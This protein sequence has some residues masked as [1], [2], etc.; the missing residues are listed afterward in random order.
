MKN[1]TV[2]NIILIW[3]AWALIVIGF[4]AL[5]TARLQPTW[6][7]R[8]LDW[9]TAETGPAYQ[10]NR[11]YLLEPF[12][13]NQVAW[14]SEYYL[15]TAIGGY[16]DPLVPAMSQYGFIIPNFATHIPTV[17]AGPE[18]RMSL[19][20]AFLPLYPLLI[21]FVAYPLSLLG[22][23]AIA[24]A[25]LAAVLVSLLGTLAG[26]LASSRPAFSWPK[27]IP[28]G[29]LSAWLLAVWRCSNAGIL[30]RPLCLA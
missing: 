1:S 9:T 23:N 2:R 17:V 13:N 25:T 28:K 6:P 5:A 8:A 18:G 27:S 3:L 12:M 16:D 29:S 10:K 24:T 14:D 15:G 22:M 26:M 19:S 21:R 7:D 30:S 11:T 20:Y 4:Q